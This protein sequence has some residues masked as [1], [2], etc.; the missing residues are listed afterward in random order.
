VSTENP[1]PTNTIWTWGSGSSGKLGDNTTVNKSS[2]V[3]IVGGFT[4]WCQVSGG[5]NGNFAAVRR[6]GTAWAWGY[7]G[8]GALGDCTVVS[9]SSP[10]SVV[11]GFTNWSQVA[12]G[13]NHTVGLRQDGTLYSWGYNGQGQIGDNTTANKSSPVSVVGG[14]TNWCQLAAGNKNSFGIRTNGVLYAWGYNNSGRLGTNS[15]VNRSSPV[16]VVGGFTDWCGVHNCNHTLGVRTNGTAWAWGCGYHG[17]LGNGQFGT[18]ASPNLRSSPVSVIGGFTNW[19]QVSGGF[20]FSL[21]VR[22]DG[23]LYAWGVNTRGQLGTNTPCSASTNSPVAIVGGFTD[24]CQV[25]GAY[26]SSFALR[27]NGTAWSWGY[28]NSGMLG[29]NSLVSKSSPVSVVGGFTD[30][31]QITAGAYGAAGL[32]SSEPYIIN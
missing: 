4:D 26:Q 1:L 9:K 27:T 17:Q 25:S 13:A 19:C 30:W 28:N 32:R 20:R 7:N 22:T 18:Y 6:N 29:D 3:S 5:K 12:A 23:T 10:V 16:S 11:G 15:T 8:F 31:C 14:F 2:P 21:G 24:W